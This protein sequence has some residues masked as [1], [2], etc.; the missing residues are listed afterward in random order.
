MLAELLFIKA[1][2]FPCKTSSATNPHLGA[3][4]GLLLHTF[5]CT[6]PL[7]KLTA[8][9]NSTNTTMPWDTLVLL[10]PRTGIKLFTLFLCHQQNQFCLTTSQLIMALQ[11]VQ[12]KVILSATSGFC[13]ALIFLCF[14]RNGWDFSSNTLK[15][16]YL[17]KL[18]VF[19]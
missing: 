18:Y 10:S 13:F 12:D 11:S 16:L 8:I 4:P 7:R 6:E 15:K 17:P 14:L 3:V 2:H 9:R 19:Y 1:V 5:S